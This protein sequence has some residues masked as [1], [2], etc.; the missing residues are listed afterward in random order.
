[1]TVWA[2]ALG[3]ILLAGCST[4]PEPG[5]AQ[6]RFDG[7]SGK[8]VVVSPLPVTRIVSTMQSATEWLVRLG[9]ESLLVARTDYDHEPALAHLPSIGGGL[10]AS[11]EAIAKLK[12]DVVLGW[13]IGASAALERALRPLGIPVVAV[14]AGDTAEVFKQLLTLGRLTGRT[15]RA[16]SLATALRGQLDSLTRSSCQAGTD[17]ESALIVLGTEPPTVAGGGSWMSQL[18]GAACLRNVF[19]DVKRPWPIV[20]LEA[21]V[22][23]QPHWLIGSRLR[24]RRSSL[25]QFR[26][27][28]GWQDLAAVRA[29]RVIEIDADIFSRA[30]PGL[31]EWVRALQA[32]L[33]T[34]RARG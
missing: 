20:S 25:S 18:L 26:K 12:P 3:A 1:M 8:P 11:A 16:E 13:R 15:T 6:G 14:E 33:G 28:A 17:P 34:I 29:G 31:A 7:P 5:T 23:R 24:G 30:G 2:P 21:I 22:Q 32:Q 9:A 10:D 19:N 27:L 4:A